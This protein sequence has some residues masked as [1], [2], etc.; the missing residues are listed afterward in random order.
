MSDTEG[1]GRCHGGDLG[2]SSCREREHV[3]ERRRRYRLA[4][5]SIDAA[6]AVGLWWLISSGRDSAPIGATEAILNSLNR[7]LAPYGLV[8]SP[9][10]RAVV[11]WAVFG[12]AVVLLALSAREVVIW[13]RDRSPQR[14]FV[15]DPVRQS[16][17]GTSPPAAEMGARIRKQLA[18]AGVFGGDQ[19]P[20]G[21]GDLQLATQELGAQSG[22]TLGALLRWLSVVL[23]P[24]GGYELHGVACRE[25][26]NGE[27]THRLTID[28][29]HRRTGASVLVDSFEGRDESDVAKVCA[30]AVYTFVNSTG[31]GRKLVP[32]WNR[33]SKPGHAMRLLHEA[34]EQIRAGGLTNALRTL[35]Q[36][37]SLEPMNVRIR[38]KWNDVYREL[39]L[40][41]LADSAAAKR[42]GEAER[43]AAHQRAAAVDLI[44]SVHASCLASCVAPKLAESRL[45][46]GQSLSYVEHWWAAWTDP[47]GAS[48]DLTS[49]RDLPLSTQRRHIDESLRFL[50]PR[51]RPR[52]LLGWIGLDPIQGWQWSRPQ[53]PDDVDEWD[54][55]QLLRFAEANLTWVI[56][57]SSTV[58][59]SL[60]WLGLRETRR[61][62]ARSP[63][64]FNPTNQQLKDSTRAMRVQV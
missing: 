58:Y 64:P 36:A 4:V 18:R 57:R 31:S 48:D 53:L 55:D 46:L 26:V 54:R 19:T 32:V 42:K 2:S 45:R 43:S 13:A 25:D 24:S 15:I 40:R 61:S 49:I 35:E 41:T 47:A 33:W 34:D 12:T 10:A 9:S 14:I 62:L 39:A 3:M 23:V 50:W 56:T 51:T 60:R 21:A 63:L 30:Y 17:E 20:G 59:L 27:D 38:L 22:T 11:G 5:G 52:W 29:R 1:V 16:L 8:V 44:N 7:L 6:F 37:A 28:L